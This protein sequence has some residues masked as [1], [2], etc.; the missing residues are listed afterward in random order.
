VNSWCQLLSTFDR[1]DPEGRAPNGW[2]SFLRPEAHKALIVITDDSAV[3][4]FER[5]EI[6]VQFGAPEADPYEDALAFHR[7][8][9]ATSPE[10]FGA[11]PDVRYRFYSFVGMAPHELA[12][13]PW[14]PHEDLS[15][16]LCD[17]AASAGLAYQAL[18]VITDALRYPVCEG[19]GFDVVFRAL[20]RSVIESTKA[21]CVFQIPSAPVDQSINLRTISL[22]YRAGGTA[23]P[24]QLAQVENRDAC[25][26]RSFYVRG[27]Q[28]ELCPDACALVEADPAAQLDVLYECQVIP[29]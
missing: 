1:S 26:D 9:L 5:G 20:A 4:T 7:A 23:A 21:S 19:R 8:L 12:T 25:D 6:S 18:S 17:T 27:E 10:Q 13:E 24:L 11:A 28:L 3:C 29:E 16:E 22:E 15:A 2:Q 14:F